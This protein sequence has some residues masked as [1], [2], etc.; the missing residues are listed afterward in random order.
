[1]R[2][3]FPVSDGAKTQPDVKGEEI[4]SPDEALAKAAA[5]ARRL[6]Q[7]GCRYDSHV[8]HVIDE[9]H[10]QIGSVAVAAVRVG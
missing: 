5:I 3:F 10:A 8:V 6:R 2:Y 1:M 7:S 4:A 9:R